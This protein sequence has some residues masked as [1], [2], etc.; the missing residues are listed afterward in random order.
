MNSY[1]MDA[2][3]ESPPAPL[4]ERGEWHTHRPMPKGSSL[5]Q[6][7]DRRDSTARFRRNNLET[8]P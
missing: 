3:R 7:E 8:T 6:R 4:W 1:L 2:S 5:S